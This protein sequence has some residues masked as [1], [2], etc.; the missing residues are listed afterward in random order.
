MDKKH[1]GVINY[2][3]D[4]AMEIRCSATLDIII[5]RLDFINEKIEVD[6]EEAKA[7]SLEIVRNIRNSWSNIINSETNCQKIK[8][9]FPQALQ[10][11]HVDEPKK[12][13]K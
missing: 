4:H 9:L 6:S 13:L 2:L 7:M 10:P 12:T 3:E 1:H 5:W 8:I 11:F